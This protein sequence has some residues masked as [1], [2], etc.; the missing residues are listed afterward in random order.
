MMIIYLVIG[1]QQARFHN[2]KS[3]G[4][5]IMNTYNGSLQHASDPRLQPQSVEFY[6]FYP[7]HKDRNSASLPFC[8]KTSFR[9]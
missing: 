8:P 4:P 3:A 7:V 2:K 1:M 5:I 6:R 9:Q